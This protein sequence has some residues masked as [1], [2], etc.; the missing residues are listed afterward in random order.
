MNKLILETKETLDNNLEVLEIIGNTTRL[1]IENQVEIDSILF[2]EVPF[3]TTW[4]LKKGAKVLICVAEE[5]SKLEGEINIISEEYTN[6]VFHLGI[7]AKDKNNLE[8]KN[9]LLKDNCSS[10]IKIRIA[11]SKDANIYLKATGDI[12]KGVKNVVYLEDIK[13][14]NEYPSS[15]VCLPELLV[16]SD[17]AVANHNMTVASIDE[18]T[19]FSLEARGL[20]EEKSRELI[21]K[22]FVESMARKDGI[23]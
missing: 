9:T 11:T 2:P 22:S 10:D 18:E 20:N 6:L 21:R 3:K 1:E 16:E 23:L 15:I 13:Y 17:D 12:K 8:I 7:Y 4:V 19:L 5:I 14:L